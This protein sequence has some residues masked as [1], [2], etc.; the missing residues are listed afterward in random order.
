MAGQVP[1]AIVVESVAELK[2]DVALPYVASLRSRFGSTWTSDIV[3]LAAPRLPVN[4]ST[5]YGMPYRSC[6]II[7]TTEFEEEWGRPS[8]QSA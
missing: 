6:R 8:A 7:L 2:S 1:A 3:H 5:Y 4:S